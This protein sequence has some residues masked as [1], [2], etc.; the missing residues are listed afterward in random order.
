MSSDIAHAIRHERIINGLVNAAINGGLAWYLFKAQPVLLL[1]GSEG[2][3]ADLMA[4]AFI[5]LFIVALIVVSIFRRKARLGKI[6]ATWDNGR[7]LHR[8]LQRFPHSLLGSA[9]MFGLIGMLVFVPPT[10]L[11]LSVSNI[12][13]LTPA[14][15]AIFKGC[16]AGSL[17]AVMVG[18][19]IRLA[20]SRR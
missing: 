4:T 8:Q 10:L 3:G 17:A 5:M 16:W 11:V 9:S 7:W 6:S 15:Y 20:V 19:M 13:E 2:F 18:S 12:T 1:W 14:Q